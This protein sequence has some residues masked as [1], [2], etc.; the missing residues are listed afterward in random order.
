M[1]NHSINVG[2]GHIHDMFLPNRAFDLNINHSLAKVDKSSIEDIG[3]AGAYDKRGI[4]GTTSGQY[5]QQSLK[6]PKMDS[7][8]PF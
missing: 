6:K 4:Y 5:L 8:V 1:L 3:Y 7:R 2:G